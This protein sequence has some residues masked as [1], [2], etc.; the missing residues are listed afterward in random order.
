MYAS[1]LPLISP[2]GYGK[3]N[4]SGWS[5]IKPGIRAGINDLQ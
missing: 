2:A 4:I 3:E 5:L 1:L